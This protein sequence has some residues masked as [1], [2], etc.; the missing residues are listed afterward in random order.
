[1]TRCGGRADRVR[2]SPRSERVLRSARGHFLPLSE[3]W[4]STYFERS[5][6]DLDLRVSVDLALLFL[7]LFP[8]EEWPNCVCAASVL[9]LHRCQTF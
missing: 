9:A 3:S 1:M 5:E 7:S 6:P 8:E 2:G 4:S